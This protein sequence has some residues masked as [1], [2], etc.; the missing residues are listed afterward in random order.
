M[1]SDMSKAWYLVI[2]TNIKFIVIIQRTKYF[3]EILLGPVYLPTQC[4]YW[5]V[6]ID[7]DFFDFFRRFLLDRLSNNFFY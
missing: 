6:A 1:T 2:T 7:S 3:E 4:V 5:F